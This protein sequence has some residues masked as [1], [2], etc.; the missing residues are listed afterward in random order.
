VSAA[1]SFDDL[2]VGDALPRHEFRVERLDLVRYCGASGDFN[3]IHWSDTAAAA[4]GLPDV[5]AHGMLTMAKS[6]NGVVA[7][8]GDPSAI[9]EYGVRFVRPVVV[10]VDG[11]DTVTVDGTIIEKLD[12]RRARIELTVTSGDQPVLGRAEVIVQL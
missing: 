12:H 6:C 9:V 11:S 5:I 1:I 4:A 7:W 10:P 2:A 3:A 8:V